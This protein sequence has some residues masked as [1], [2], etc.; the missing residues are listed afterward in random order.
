MD[1]LKRDFEKRR[2]EVR[3]YLK[4]LRQI[5]KEGGNIESFNV[6]KGA[7]YVMSYN[8]VES[9]VSNCLIE[10]FNRIVSD[11][12]C[13]DQLSAPLKSIVW[14]RTKKKSNKNHQL[15]SNMTSIA[16][17]IVK[18]AISDDTRDFIS[19]NLNIE[20]IEEL[21][22]KFGFSKQI[23][24]KIFGRYTKCQGVDDSY[25]HRN[26]LAHGSKSFSEVGKDKTSREL[27]YAY[28]EVV[29]YLSGLIDNVERF[30]SEKAHMV[31]NS[32]TDS[33]S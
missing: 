28:Q 17:D 30:L 8:L 22:D 27:R 11:G 10:I 32:T 31:Q 1:N 25:R 33:L 23:I 9:T 19:G 6:L 14:D 4:L 3:A 12:A 5:E 15:T 18:E 7:F 24:V 2:L 16:L 13:F 20:K 29:R 26:D 21:A